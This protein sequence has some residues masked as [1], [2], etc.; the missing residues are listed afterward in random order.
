M[1]LGLKT[2]TIDGQ[3]NPLVTAKTMKFNEVTTQFVLT[4]HVL[5]YDVLAVSKKVWSSFTPAQQAKF[6][7]EADKIFDAN[8]AEYDKQEKDTVEAFKKEGKKVYTPDQNAFRAFAQKRYVDKY[9]KD[10]PKGA[11]EAINAIK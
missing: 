3:D 9:G 2:G 4:S 1:Y 10:W 5:G 7:A 11:L 6:R 8:A